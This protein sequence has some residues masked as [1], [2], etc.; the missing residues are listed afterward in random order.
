MVHARSAHTTYTWREE[1]DQKQLKL[2]MSQS[3]ESKE[4]KPASF[5]FSFHFTDNSWMG[6]RLCEPPKTA[7]KG[8]SP[9]K[10]EVPAPETAETDLRTICPPHSDANE[11]GLLP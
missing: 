6:R 1:S 4:R 8:E 11:G 9:V 7:A 3:I 2:I 10:R 5:S